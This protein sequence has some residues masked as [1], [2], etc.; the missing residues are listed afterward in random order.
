[1][2]SVLAKSWGVPVFLVAALLAG[3]CPGLRT[4]P[5]A[6]Q[7]R[8]PKA[9]RP[10]VDGNGD[11]LPPGARARL[12]TVRLRH[13]GS[14]DYLALSPDAA[15]LATGNYHAEAVIQVWET[16]R[17]KRRL[18]RAV[19]AEFNV[20][21]MA[22]TPNGKTLALAGQGIA[23][24]FARVH[25]WDVAT[26]K[27]VRRFPMPVNH[28]PFAWLASFSPDGALLAAGCDKVYL[29]DAVTGA[30]RHTLPMGR[31][32]ATAL[33]FAPDGK[34][35]ATADEDGSLRLWD[36]HTGTELHALKTDLAYTLAF[37]P[38]G[39]LLAASGP[40]RPVRLWAVTHGPGGD[41]V[42]LTLRKA[43]QGH[44][45]GATALTF[46]KDGVL[47]GAGAS[48]GG[49]WL[50]DTSTEKRQHSQ[51]WP[52]AMARAAGFDPTGRPLV[53]GGP[54]HANGLQILDATSGRP[55][56]AGAAHLDSVREL[57]YSPDG[58]T[59][60]SLC[61]A[62]MLHLWR[63]ADGSPLDRPDGLSAEM[64]GAAFSV[65]GSLLVSAGGSLSRIEL[66]GGK[67]VRL[68]LRFPQGGPLSL[69]RD[70]R[71]V[72]VGQCVAADGKTPAVPSPWEPERARWRVGVWEVA[73]G[74]KLG[75]LP[76]QQGAFLRCTLSPDGR[77]LVTVTHEVKLWEAATGRLLHRLPLDG[78]IQAVAFGPRG[79]ILAVRERHEVGLWE[80]ASGQRIRSWTL[81]T[82][83]RPAA[84]DASGTSVA[85]SADG[86]VLATDTAGGEVLFWDAGTGQLLHT[87]AG[88]GGSIRTLAF[89]PDGK[90]LAAGNADTTILLWDS[91]GVR[92]F[93]AGAL[94]PLTASD[95]GK[96]WDQL[97]DARAATA[98][99]AA[100]ALAAVPEK[101]V[102]WLR[103]RLAPA[104]AIDARRLAQLLKDLGHD[105]FGVRE[106]AM[107]ELEGLGEPAV[108]VLQKALAGPMPL[109]AKRRVEQVVMKIGRRVPEELRALRAVD[110]LERIGSAEA[111]QILR[112]VAGGAAQA[113]LTQEAQA[114]LRRLER[115]L[116]GPESAP[117]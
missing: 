69:A 3:T 39:K 36:P 56:F 7:S 22:F 82:A 12:G 11:P 55:R 16:A 2:A 110:V 49:L 76:I 26:S 78:V 31:S 51:R 91:A 96:L 14:I 101:A 114:S 4:A 42:R 71:R 47:L 65:D 68:P 1:M 38:G 30:V 37:G 95:L 83:E 112:R 90:T 58:Q 8:A 70:G 59:L 94:K 29:L 104:S 89:S 40:G 62:G 85:F 15:L 108:V 117:R 80:V 53:V 57:V 88:H 60:A 13:A 75:D 77:V 73:S 87:L 74:K 54:H 21:A 97:A 48:G 66:P 86:P 67:V 109:E 17:G 102:G 99:P 9:H 100:D 111:R 20:M 64:D 63:A 81:P 23:N 105:R 107:R 50:W 52:E 33:A 45:Q 115:G 103:G 28:R 98:Y 84:Q 72:A 46:S 18:R 92:A 43:P 44:E 27:E 10:R 116:T 106:Q 5:G 41:G 35:L 113:R 34:L 79:R 6:A 19:P 25:L 24:D 32:H 93:P 61:G